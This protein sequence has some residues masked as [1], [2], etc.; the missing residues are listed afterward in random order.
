MTSFQRARSEEQRAERRRAILST[1]ATMLAELPVAQLSLNELSRRVGLAKSNVLNYFDSRE[2]V[3][4]ELLDVETRDWIDQLDQEL[5]ATVDPSAPVGDRA[6]QLADAIVATLESRPMLCALTSAQAAVLEHNI[7]VEIATEF[8]RSSIA[9]YGLLIQHVNARVP[10]L[11]EDG[12]A[13]FIAA[14]VMLTGVLWTHSHPS[15]AILAA[16]EADPAIA[17]FRI[18]FGP[19]LREILQTVL[20]G[21]L[22]R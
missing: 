18:T 3:L 16:Y 15:A 1:A 20:T 4:L 22:P 7:S 19:A 8:K 2:A 21:V 9:N 14:A 10:E 5:T 11:G 13:R 12:A 6:G 17:N